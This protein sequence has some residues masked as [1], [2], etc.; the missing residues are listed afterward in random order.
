M[1]F[2]FG[3]K[4]F[5]YDLPSGYA[6]INTAPKDKVVINTNGQTTATAASK[7]QNNAPQAVIIEV[8]ISSNK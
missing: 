6:A 3:D 1:S 2:N 4:P 7:P 8:S 5:K